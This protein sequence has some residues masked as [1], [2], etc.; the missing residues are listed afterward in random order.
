LTRLNRAVIGLGHQVRTPDRRISV[1]ISDGSLR[2]PFL[3]RFVWDEERA[4]RCSKARIDQHDL[5]ADLA[6]FGSACRSRIEG[7]G[8][9]AKI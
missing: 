2:A 9:D 8:H 1:F 3:G 6:T 5:W 4:G 7:R